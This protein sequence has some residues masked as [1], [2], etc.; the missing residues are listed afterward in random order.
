M[1]RILKVLDKV[2]WHCGEAL[3]AIRDFS[4]QYPFDVL[5]TGFLGSIDGRS[6]FVTALH[7]LTDG[8]KARASIEVK[9]VRY[10]LAARTLYFST[11][12]DLGVFE[13][14][15][16]WAAAVSN[17]TRIPIGRDIGVWADGAH[18]VVVMGFPTDFRPNGVLTALPISTRLEIRDIDTVTEIPDARLYTLEGDELTSTNGAAN[19]YNL[20]PAGMSGGP[21]MACLLMWDGSS[22]LF[23][24]KLQS[25]LVQWHS[26]DAYLV[27]TATASLVA[28][29][30]EIEKGTAACC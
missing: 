14:D 13:L 23:L 9:G 26:P 27:G 5:G 10:S 17:I 29:I 25:V 18:S 21:A 24:C 30:D 15:E 16:E 11:D 1:S 8:V 3:L 12:D 2:G 6:Y 19:V 7:N 28:L 20:D 22:P 4:T